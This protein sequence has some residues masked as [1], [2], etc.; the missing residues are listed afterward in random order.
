MAKKPWN[1][2]RR[3]PEEQAAKLIQ[4]AAEIFKK[5]NSRFWLDYGTLLGQV[6]DGR[7]IKHDGDIDLAVDFNQW[8]PEV[9]DDLCNNGFILRKK[10]NLLTDVKV[11]KFVGEKKRNAVTQVKLGYRY[12]YGKKNKTAGI[13]ICVEIYHDGVG[14]YKDNMYFWPTPKPDW[15]FEIPKSYMV[16]QIKAIF[17]DTEI[18]IPK[19]Y[20]DNLEFMY[21]NNWRMPN[22]TYTNSDEHKENAKKFKRFFK[23][24]K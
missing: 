13:K 23:R 17:Y 24:F 2:M 3:I 16:P 5:H 20:E 10:P 19:N 4:K 11:L 12:T 7:I 22:V 21:G 1:G 18:Y 15:I 14:K 9:L 8:N 6:R